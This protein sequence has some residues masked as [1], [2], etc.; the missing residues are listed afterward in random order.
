MRREMTLYS[1]TITTI[2]VVVTATAILPSS[3]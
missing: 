1:K 2:A 3:S